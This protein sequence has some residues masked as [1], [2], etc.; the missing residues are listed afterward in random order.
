M[1]PTRTSHADITQATLRL[2][3]SVF[4]SAE[5]TEATNFYA[6][7]LIFGVSE[8]LYTGTSCL[9]SQSTRRRPAHAQQSTTATAGFYTSAP[10][11]PPTPPPPQTSWWQSW[12][13]T[14]TA[15]WWNLFS[16]DLCDGTP[17]NIPVRQL[18]QLQR[19]KAWGRMCYF[20]CMHV[21]LFSNLLRFEIMQMYRSGLAWS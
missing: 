19:E 6:V 7:S 3:W 13:C 20:K 16:T 14:C 8:V 2:A 15:N 10:I 4:L 1:S 17:R 12:W 18:Q 21:Y 11:H 9:C 5:T